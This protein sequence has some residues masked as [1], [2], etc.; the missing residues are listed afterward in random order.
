MDGYIRVQILLLC[1]MT[2][3]LFVEA[4]ARPVKR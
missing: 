3:A 1:D 2:T 4:M